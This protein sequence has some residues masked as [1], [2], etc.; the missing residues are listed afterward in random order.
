MD[1][2]DFALVMSQPEG[3]GR[4]RVPVPVQARGGRAHVRR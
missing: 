2:D 1:F 3:I 4:M